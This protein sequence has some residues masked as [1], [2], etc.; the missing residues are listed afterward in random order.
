MNTITYINILCMK[1]AKQETGGQV[2][3]MIALRKEKTKH[4]FCWVKVG[5][6]GQI[7]IPREQHPDLR[8]SGKEVIS[9]TLNGH[10]VQNIVKLNL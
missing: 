8:K 10:P 7:V 2:D 3:P 9:K 5:E 6:R 4:L 1:S